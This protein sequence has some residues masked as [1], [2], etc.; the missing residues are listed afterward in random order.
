MKIAVLLATFVLVTSTAFTQSIVYKN[1]EWSKWETDTSLTHDGKMNVTKKRKKFTS[2]NKC[3]IT[4]EIIFFHDKCNN[5]IRKTK[6]RSDCKRNIG[7]GT[8]I[9]ERKYKSKCEDKKQN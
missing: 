9:Y 1:N 4:E 6:I 2:K 5:I 7:E 8:I 3:L